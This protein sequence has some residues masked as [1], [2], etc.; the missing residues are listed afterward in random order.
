MWGVQGSAF[1]LQQTYKG[2][3]DTND[4]DYGDG[5][6]GCVG[7]GGGKEKVGAYFMME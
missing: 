2:R 7:S 5:G 3:D 4:D 1:A 6:V